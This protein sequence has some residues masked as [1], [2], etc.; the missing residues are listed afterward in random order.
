MECQKLRCVKFRPHRAV[1][2]RLVNPMFLELCITEET[3][4]RVNGHCASFIFVTAD[5][6]AGFLDLHRDSSQDAGWRKM[7][8]TNPPVRRLWAYSDLQGDVAENDDGVRL[9]QVALYLAEIV[10][11]EKRKGMEEGREEA[12]EKALVAEH[13][14]T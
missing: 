11:R 9:G 8:L 3:C 5:A 2:E 1:D 6:V 10:N 14:R 13:S 4:L 12:V 7:F